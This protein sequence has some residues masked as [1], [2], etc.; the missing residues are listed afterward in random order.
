VKKSVVLV[1]FC[2]LSITP[3]KG[4]ARGP[5]AAATDAGSHQLFHV[6]G[7]CILYLNPDITTCNIVT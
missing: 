4:L 5:V 7:C 3:G 2:D 1:A 6:C